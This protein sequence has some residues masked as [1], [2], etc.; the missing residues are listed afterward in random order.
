MRTAVTAILLLLAPQLYAADLELGIRHVATM[1]T[2]ESAFDGGELDIASSRGFAAT[3]ELFVTERFSTQLAGTFINPETIL[4]PTG[5]L[6]TDVDL[7]T[8]GLDTYSLTARYH[9]APQSR[10]S[11]FAGG[12]VAIVLIGNLEDRFGDDFELEYDPETTFIAEGGIRYRFYPRIYLDAAVSY[13]PLETEPATLK[14]APPAGV[15]LPPRLSLDPV[16]LSV[17]AAWR[18]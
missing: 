9:F 13:M 12:G 14:G 6:V 7:G 8:L 1:M 18:F 15:T 10:F 11:Y 2:G 5:G 16:T 4:F 17:G 3:A